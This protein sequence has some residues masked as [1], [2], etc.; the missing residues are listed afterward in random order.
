MRTKTSSTIVLSTKT[1]AAAAL[2]LTLATSASADTAPDKFFSSKQLTVVEKV[3]P[4]YPL[5]ADRTGRDGHAIVE[6]TVAPDGSV[7]A[8]AVRESSAP[9]FSRA[10]LEA[11]E[12]WQFEPVIDNG[13]AVPVRTN[14]KFSFVPR[15]E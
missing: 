14:V 2:A 15:T 12:S 3:T 10:A 5:F 11:I 13:I 1:L 8:P 9:M 6:F 4:A 7:T